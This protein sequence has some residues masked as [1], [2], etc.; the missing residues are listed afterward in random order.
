MKRI[1]IFKVAH[2]GKLQECAIVGDNVWLN[3]GTELIKLI[4][5]LDNISV[6]QS[7]GV[8]DLENNPIYEGHH[9]KDEGGNIGKIVWS[10]RRLTWLIHD[11]N[12]NEYCTLSTT[13]GVRIIGHTGISVETTEFK[14][15]LRELSDE[16][17]KY[18]KS[19]DQS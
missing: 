3:K 14:N 17:I 18:L 5:N 11:F 12:R 16:I 1:S 9:V 7:T 8:L 15:T 10:H 2:E 19:G 6:Y 13:E 4:G